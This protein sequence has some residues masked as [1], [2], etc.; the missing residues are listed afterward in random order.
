VHSRLASTWGFHLDDICTEVS[1][2]LATEKPLLVSEIQYPIWL[3]HSLLPH[4]QDVI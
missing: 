2:D 1:E 4:Y 3:E